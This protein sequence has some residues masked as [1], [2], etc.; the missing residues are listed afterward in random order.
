[1]AKETPTQSKDAGQTPEEGEEKK[2]INRREFLNLAWL[3]S[4][5]FMTLSLGGVTYLFV[6][7]RFKEGEFGGSFD[8]GAPSEL[9]ETTAGPGNFPKGKF[10]LSNT[11]A[12]VLALYKVCTHLG[13]LYSW[14]EQ[15][16]RF[17]CPC[18]GSQFEKEGVFIQGPAPR[19]LD[20]FIVRAVDAQTGEILAETPEDG[21]PM[22][23]PTNGENVRIV[24]D[25][26]KRIKGLPK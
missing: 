24:V 4:L 26:G 12:G 20:Q 19:S 25:T 17:K 22:P 7:P 8:V 9:P 1:M 2:K 13:C 3:A 23:I 15:E 5:G 10:W 21:G 18:H 11:E 16:F 14:S 6:M